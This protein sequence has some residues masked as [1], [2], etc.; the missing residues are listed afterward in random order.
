MT[1]VDVYIWKQ[2]ATNDR[3]VD[4]AMSAIE[5]EMSPQFDNFTTYPIDKSY[6][7]NIPNSLVYD[8]S[9]DAEVVDEF[10][11]WVMDKEYDTPTE[12]APNDVHLLL[13]EDSTFS[14][15]HMYGS[16]GSG[17]GSR[18]L[19]EDDTSVEDDGAIGFVNARTAP[20]AGYALTG[21]TVPM[22]KN[23]VMHEVYHALTYKNAIYYDAPKH[24]CSSPNGVHPDHSLGK[25]YEGS[26]DESSPMA[27][28]YTPDAW[29]TQPCNRCIP[30][31]SGDVESASHE[32]T[33]CAT[34]EA[35]EHVLVQLD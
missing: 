26:T 7:D 28:W 29:N 17:L 24:L 12:P 30:S 10:G 9:T 34:R 22:F 3:W 27:T 33:A 4:S 32:F 6:T 18:F 13:L 5:D 35:E 20:S 19:A 14:A 15:G 25:I 31:G 11:T 16:V 23:T 21:E 1:Y 8:A 2:D